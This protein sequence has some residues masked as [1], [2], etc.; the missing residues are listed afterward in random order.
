M[1]CVTD[2]NRQRVGCVI[3]ARNLFEAEDH[4]HHGLHQTLVGLA[5]TGNG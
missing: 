3:R 5:V 4:L 2:G 1:M